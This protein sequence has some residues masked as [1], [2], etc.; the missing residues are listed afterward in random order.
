MA[1][2]HLVSEKSVRSTSIRSEIKDSCKD[3]KSGRATPVLK[4]DSTRT[5]RFGYFEA[6]SRGI[7]EL[8]VKNS[9]EN[10]K[11]SYLNNLNTEGSHREDGELSTTTEQH[12]IEQCDIEFIPDSN[13]LTSGNNS[14]ELADMS[15]VV[16]P[17]EPINVPPENSGNSR[18][19]R[20]T[21]QQS[22][23]SSTSSPTS[24]LNKLK[25]TALK[26]WEELNKT[27]TYIDTDTGKKSKTVSKLAQ[28]CLFFGGILLG[29]SLLM[30]I[31]ICIKY[32]NNNDSDD[33]DLNSGLVVQGEPALTAIKKAEDEK[34][35][36][37]DNNIFIT[38]T[39]PPEAKITNEQIDPVT[40]LKRSQ[41]PYT[42][43]ETTQIEKAFPV[44][45]KKGC[46]YWVKIWCLTYAGC[47]SIFCIIDWCSNLQFWGNCYGCCYCC[48]SC[49]TKCPNG[50]CWPCDC[51][52]KTG[53]TR[54]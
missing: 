16:N 39:P 20:T 6:I 52:Y 32:A 14:K 48:P 3:G 37:E 8:V 1:T 30:S 24:P 40:G 33:P 44:S 31:N 54:C 17:E 26:N 34:A 46:Y 28:I 51:C 10:D 36:A 19:S 42:V 21:S 12:H 9:F 29:I 2:R 47:W 4:S 45:R 5:S 15:R 43:E 22:N 38:K 7:S 50:D 49:F 27:H 25:T 13:I 35:E 11:N 53:V 41:T 23:K 18:L